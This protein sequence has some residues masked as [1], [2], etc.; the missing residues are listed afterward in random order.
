MNDSRRA[1]E[2]IEQ[3]ALAAVA[4]DPLQ[5]EAL[6]WSYCAS[7]VFEVPKSFVDRINLPDEA[8]ASIHSALDAVDSVLVVSYLTSERRPEPLTGGGKHYVFLLNPKS[9]IVL[10]TG[11]GTWRS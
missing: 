4:A 7:D 2:E 6:G 11:V 1:S 3:L 8:K 10:Y 9:L 5:K